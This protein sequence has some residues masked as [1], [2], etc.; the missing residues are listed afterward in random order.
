MEAHKLIDTLR[1]CSE[2]NP[3]IDVSIFLSVSRDGVLANRNFVTYRVRNGSNEFLMLI[4]PESLAAIEKTAVEFRGRHVDFDFGNYSHDEKI[5]LR[6]SLKRMIK[7]LDEEI[8]QNGQ[9]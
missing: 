1:R 6:A 3:D 2:G 8:R 4:P 5:A 9:V 7:E